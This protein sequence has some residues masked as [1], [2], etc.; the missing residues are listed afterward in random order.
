MDFIL[1]AR[2]LLRKVHKGVM[3]LRNHLVYI[4]RSGIEEKGEEEVV[5]FSRSCLTVKSKPKALQN[6]KSFF[7]FKESPVPLLL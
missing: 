1:T 3:S 5:F 4:W 7:F 6:R 2:E